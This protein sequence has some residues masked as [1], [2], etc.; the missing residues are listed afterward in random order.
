MPSSPS[1]IIE[2][3]T[4]FLTLTERQFSK[5]TAYSFLDD[6]A[7]VS[8]AVLVMVEYWCCDSRVL[9]EYWWSTG[10]VIVASC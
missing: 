8:P 6:L 5:K 9:V 4:C 3:Q 10:V 7:Q 2:Q 1:Y